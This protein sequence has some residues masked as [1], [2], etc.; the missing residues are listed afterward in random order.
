MP[1]QVRRMSVPTVK[2][3]ISHRPVA[4]GLYQT[5][6]GRLCRLR[7]I[8]L[9]E[10]GEPEAELVYECAA[11]SAAGRNDGFSFASRAWHLLRRL[12]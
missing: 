12:A 4:G 10:D 8:T 7:A 11:V 6:A 1:R 3:R 9:A 5:P 2:P